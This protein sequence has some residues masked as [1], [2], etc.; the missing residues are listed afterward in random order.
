MVINT[1]QANSPPPILLFSS[2]PRAGTPEGQGCQQGAGKAHRLSLGHLADKMQPK[3]R[4]LEQD[5]EIH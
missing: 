3:D 5:Q 4:K 1:T 2:P